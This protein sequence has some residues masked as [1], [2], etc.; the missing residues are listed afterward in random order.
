MFINRDGLITGKKK[1][2]GWGCGGLFD[3]LH[4]TRPIALN[5]LVDSDSDRWGTIKNNL[6]I[7]P[8][9]ALRAENS[10][11]VI[12]LIYSS[13]ATNIRHQI[14]ELGNFQCIDANVVL[15]ERYSAACARIAEIVKNKVRIENS[16]DQ[17]S[18]IL[19]QGPFVEG[20]TESLLEYYSKAFPDACLVYSGWK[21][22]E[23][24]REKFIRP[25]VDAI[26]ENEMPALKGVQNRNLQAATTREGLKAIREIGRTYVMKVR[27][28][29]LV[30][31]PSVLSRT[32][33]ILQSADS[34]VCKQFGL[35]GRIAIPSSFT[36]KY[37]PYHPSD[38]VMLGYVDDLLLYWSVA[39]D[40]R[41]FDIDDLVSKIS[42]DKL[43]NHGLVAESYFG[44]QFAKR[45]GRKLEGSLSDSLNFLRDFFMVF[46][47]E[48]FELFWTK[49]PHLIAN[50]A[51]Y[52][53]QE[54]INNNFWMELFKQS[55]I[56][57]KHSIDVEKQVWKVG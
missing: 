56:H 48:W 46:D 1:L 8:P 23:E 45:I 44:T 11:E 39:D 54:N 57:M 42:L 27:S 6:E 5:Y 4:A 31:K 17:M 22:A 30:G 35:N 51:Q 19:I 12:I 24:V 9:A 7:R 47:D 41:N 34:L 53:W 43:G 18:A 16:V 2:V 20:V 13:F 49:S 55:S 38:L 33:S 10:S 21:L 37:I 32:V 14:S 29:L 3:R 28:D 52:P 36:R 25:H 50:T 15:D 40:D 26:I